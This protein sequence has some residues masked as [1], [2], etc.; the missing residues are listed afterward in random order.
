MSSMRWL[1]RQRWVFLVIE[2]N[3]ETAADEK[4]WENAYQQ[5]CA[6]PAVCNESGYRIREPPEN[7]AEHK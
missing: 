3:T 5:K 4:A 6:V 7:Q 2:D 1:R